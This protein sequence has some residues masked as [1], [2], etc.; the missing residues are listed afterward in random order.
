MYGRRL[1]ARPLPGWP[2][3]GHLEA[4]AGALGREKEALRTLAEEEAARLL[5]AL[6]P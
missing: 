4:L 1:G 5:R 3:S 6:A 2:L